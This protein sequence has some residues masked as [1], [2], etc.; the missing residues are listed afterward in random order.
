MLEEAIDSDGQTSLLWAFCMDIHSSQKLWKSRSTKLMMFKIFWDGD[1]KFLDT[2]L[3][4]SHPCAV[5]HV[6]FHVLVMWWSCDILVSCI[7]RWLCH[8]LVL[9]W[10]FDGHVMVMWCIHFCGVLQSTVDFRGTYFMYLMWHVWLY[11]QLLFV[12]PFK[13]HCNSVKCTECNSCWTDFYVCCVHLIL[14]CLSDDR[15]NDIL[16]EN[17]ARFSVMYVSSDQWVI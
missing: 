11:V 10:S 12:F 14:C 4:C 9:W 16:K 2:S 8:L 1:Q 15:F 7:A 5:L 17:N 3:W 13:T 6:L